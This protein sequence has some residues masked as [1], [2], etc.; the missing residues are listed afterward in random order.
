MVRNEPIELYSFEMKYFNPSTVLIPST[1]I[2]RFVYYY[3]SFI[4]AE[5]IRTCKVV[6]KVYEWH[7]GTAVPLSA[8]IFDFRYTAPVI[9]LPHHV[10]LSFAVWVPGDFGNTS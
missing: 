8:T 10:L 3:L 7:Q 5:K 2:I 4:P 6:K 9:D 1:P